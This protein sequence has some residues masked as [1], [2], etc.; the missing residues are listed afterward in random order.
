MHGGEWGG[1]HYRITGVN[2]TGILQM[3]GGWQNNRPSK[4]HPDKRFVENVFEELDAPGEWFLDKE[5]KLLYFYP[6]KILTWLLPK[7]KW[8]TWPKAL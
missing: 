2:A 4:L 6:L 7:L 3:E 1:F 5:K 8:P